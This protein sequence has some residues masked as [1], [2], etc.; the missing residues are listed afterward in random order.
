MEL[1]LS[2]KTLKYWFNGR[3]QVTRNHH[4]IPDGRWY[5]LVKI[6]NIGNTIILNPFSQSEEANNTL[7]ERL[8]KN[9]QIAYPPSLTDLQNWMLIQG[10]HNGD[11]T[12][13]EYLREHFFYFEETYAIAEQIH[14]DMNGDDNSYALIKF[15]S[16]EM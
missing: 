8:G 11:W 13:T 14:P 9:N 16:Y 15:V 12:S 7:P 10:I 1:D 6:R 4:S 2:T 5:P 3:H